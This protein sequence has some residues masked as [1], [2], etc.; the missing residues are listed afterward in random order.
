MRVILIADRLFASR[1]RDMLRRLQIGLADEGVRTLVLLPPEAD[2]SVQVALAGHT[3]TLPLRGPLMTARAFYGEVSARITEAWGDSASEPV[4]AV[5]VFGGRSWDV[6][7]S[8]SQRFG[9]GMVAEVW[10]AGLIGSVRALH[11]RAAGRVPLVLSCPG[12]VLAE[13]VRET[14]P[15]ADVRSIQWG[16]HTSVASPRRVGSVTSVMLCGSGRDSAPFVQ[17]FEAIVR[18]SESAVP[19]MIF[20]DA[21]SAERSKLWRAAKDLDALDRLSL[22]DEMEARR[23]LVLRGAVV[24]QPEARGEHR[25]IVLDAMA[26][27]AAVVA[28]RDDL[29]EALAGSSPAVLVED[30]GSEEWTTEVRRVLADHSLRE[31]VGLDCHAWAAANHR[32]TAHIAAVERMYRSMLDPAPIPFA[33]DGGSAAGR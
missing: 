23:H 29:V 1:E 15:K 13:R 21:T 16:V 19:V 7:L 5:H 2:R 18:A 10:R 26:H 24:V 33:P 6:G 20:A 31:G 28:K 14:V 3:A 8:L 32:A 12:D 25:S 27:H 30:G 22:I 11:A 9:A 4:A 17:A